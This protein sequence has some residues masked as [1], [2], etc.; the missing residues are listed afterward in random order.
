MKETRLRSTHSSF[1]GF[2]IEFCQDVFRARLAK[3]A[4]EGGDAP[5][6]QKPGKKRQAHNNPQLPVS[7]ASQIMAVPACI[8]TRIIHNSEDFC[9]LTRKGSAASTYCIPVLTPDIYLE[10][11]TVE[12]FFQTCYAVLYCSICHS[13]VQEEAEGCLPQ[14]SCEQICF[15]NCEGSWWDLTMGFHYTEPQHSRKSARR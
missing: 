7:P 4:D 14:T 9:K 6:Q 1:Q 3:R 11:T 5:S 13:D 2:S 10:Y 15:F 12:S 8:R